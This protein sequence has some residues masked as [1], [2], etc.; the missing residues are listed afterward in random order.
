MHLII[1]KHEMHKYTSL[2]TINSVTATQHVFKINFDQY[3]PI[4]STCQDHSHNM[5]HTKFACSIFSLRS[6]FKR[7]GL[8][9]HSCDR[10]NSKHTTRNIH[11]PETNIINILLILISYYEPFMFQGQIYHK[12]A[13][14]NLIP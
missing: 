7:K 3:S 10:D 13:Y 4:I 5:H 9:N 6:F 1:T 2:Y 12:P 14:K 8:H 11:V